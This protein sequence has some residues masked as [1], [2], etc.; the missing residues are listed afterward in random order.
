MRG[1][2]QSNETYHND[3]ALQQEEDTLRYI[4]IVYHNGSYW[5]LKLSAVGPT[6]EATLTTEPGSA[7]DIYWK[8]AQG[9]DFA[10]IGTL[11]AEYLNVYSIDTDEIRIHNRGMS[12]SN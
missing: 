2:W 6:G 1:E 3:S 10:Y 9:I 11:V 5:M 4:D 12:D 8:E 7:G